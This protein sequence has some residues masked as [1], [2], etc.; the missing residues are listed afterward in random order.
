MT[1]DLAIIGECAAA[2]A[3]YLFDEL[4]VPGNDG[5]VMIFLLLETGLCHLLLGPQQFL[6]GRLQFVHVLLGHVYRVC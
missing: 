3:R 6:I 1:L 2:R 4:L 5:F